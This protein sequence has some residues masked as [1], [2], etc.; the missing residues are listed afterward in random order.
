MLFIKETDLSDPA[1]NMLLDESHNEAVCFMKQ[2]KD[3]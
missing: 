2:T 1:L 3:L